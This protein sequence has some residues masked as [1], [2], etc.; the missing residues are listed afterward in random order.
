MRRVTTILVVLACVL[1]IAL[2]L[3]SRRKSDLHLARDSG[4][5]AI[6]KVSHALVDAGPADA[7]SR[8]PGEKLSAQSDPA[9]FPKCR[10]LGRVVDVNA[11][12]QSGVAV[13]FHWQPGSETGPPGAEGSL[14]PGTLESSTSADGRFTIDAPLPDFRF[15][16]LVVEPEA[17]RRR[18][19]RQ[20][21]TLYGTDRRCL[22]EGDNDLGDIVLDVASAVSG[23]VVSKDG[24]PIGGVAISTQDA[25]EDGFQTDAQSDASG[26]F[27]LAHLAAGQHTFNAS[28]SGWTSIDVSV[29]TR[30]GETL[31]AGDT[32]LVPAP[33]ISGSVV[34]DDGKALPRIQVMSNGHQTTTGSDGTFTLDV[35]DDGP[36]YLFAS[37]L[38][39]FSIANDLDARFEPGTKDVRIVLHRLPRGTFRVVDGP[40]REPI[41]RFGITLK[42]GSHFGVVGRWDRNGLDMVDHPDGT[43][44][45]PLW[46]DT[47]VAWAPGHAPLETE[48]APEALNGAQAL[49]LVP[50]SSLS[51]RLVRAGSPVPH[52]LVRLLRD[53]VDPVT[54]LEHAP[55]P[56]V[57]N[58]RYDL[59]AYAGRLRTTS[60]D[61][62]GR[63]HF[64]DLAAGTYALQFDARGIARTI[65]R[66]RVV[67][68]EKE[69]ELGEIELAAGATVHGVL[70]VQAGLSPKGFRVRMEPAL[71]R[72]TTV[73]ASGKFTFT[74]LEP[75]V[76]VLGWAPPDQPWSAPGSAREQRVDLAA[77]EARDVILDARSDVRCAVTVH[78]LRAGK[79]AAG[80]FV[81]ARSKT[82]D[83]PPRWDDLILGGTGSDG[84]IT[85]YVDPGPAF[86]LEPRLASWRALAGTG[87]DLHATAGGSIEATFELT[88]GRLV[89]VL[90]K[91]VA[92][93]ELGQVR[94]DL[95]G[96]AYEYIVV[97][98]MTPGL[99][100]AQA[101][102]PEWSGGEID[103][104][105]LPARAFHASINVQRFERDEG[106]KSGEYV[107]LVRENN[108]TVTIEDGRETRIVVTP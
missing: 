55:D 36:C 104:G 13:K 8:A 44:S 51:G 15:A 21:G 91:T 24:K 53:D 63:Y 76:H 5:K 89:L 80:V 27:V 82:A 86:D 84:S 57:S 59:G 97:T 77:G 16:V 70:T 99:R 66:G 23:R 90:P 18:A 43:A 88:S 41:V 98:A 50:A 30:A 40:T 52:A 7:L 102:G 35:D 49:A 65:M 95:R 28:A 106:G 3:D 25:I 107:D 58:V 22:F 38:P 108:I 47:V 72:W 75:G 61:A 87:S 34:D 19:I 31:D 74:D 56:Q 68:P 78:V 85:A 32:V 100:A 103:F 20:F 73:D 83:K 1:G 79:P 93:P 29:E 94:V 11:V 54:R 42:F 14:D 96:P 17:H 33:T 6:D 26:R 81:V 39:E 69:L 101:A 67:L 60:T 105:E 9:N 62:N 10:I 4:S 71:G 12:A 2:F 64:G 46:A 37:G 48:I 45:L 92:I